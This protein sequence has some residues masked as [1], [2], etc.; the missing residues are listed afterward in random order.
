VDRAL[1]IGE[2]PVLHAVA[3]RLRDDG[4]GRRV[5]AAALGISEEDVPTMLEIADAKLRRLEATEE[6]PW[7]TGGAT[8]ASSVRQA[9][10]GPEAAV[11][12]RV[13]PSIDANVHELNQPRR[14]TR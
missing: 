1:A 9:D 13:A 14:S 11:Q 12:Q 3:I 10:V 7:P 6:T 2:L 8:G 4:A 5:I